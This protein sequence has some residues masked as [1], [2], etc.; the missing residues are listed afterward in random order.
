MDIIVASWIIFIVIV[1]VLFFALGG[2]RKKKRRQEDSPQSGVATTPTGPLL[3][4]PAYG[5]VTQIKWWRSMPESL[6]MIWGIVT[7]AIVGIVAIIWYS[8]GWPAVQKFWKEISSW[9]GKGFTLSAAMGTF[10]VLQSVGAFIPNSKRL[11][12]MVFIIVALIAGFF[13]LGWA[14]FV[15]GIIVPR[16]L[17]LVPITLSLAALW[18]SGG[19]GLPIPLFF[20]VG[21][22][23]LSAFEPTGIAR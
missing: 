22:V 21:W 7:L 4:P 17:I 6:S 12:F 3:L 14:W 9:G 11:P 23:I 19:E 10:F 15:P 5:G 1:S 13:L 18:K 16:I 8:E 2:G 20:F